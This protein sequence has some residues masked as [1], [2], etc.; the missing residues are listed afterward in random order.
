MFVIDKKL[1]LFLVKENWLL[2]KK[3]LLEDY[4]CDDRKFSK[5]QKSKSMINYII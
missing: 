3:S 4:G 2:D 1:K 5:I